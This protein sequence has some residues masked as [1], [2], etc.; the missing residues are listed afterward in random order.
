MRLKASCTAPNT[1][2]TLAHIALT[3]SLRHLRKIN[4]P[5]AGDRQGLEREKLPTGKNPKT[6]AEAGRELM[7]GLPGRRLKLPVIGTQPLLKA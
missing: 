6:R 7:A 4:A 2:A 5:K 1:P 3:L